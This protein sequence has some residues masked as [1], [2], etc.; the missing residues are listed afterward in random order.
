MNATMPGRS[1]SATFVVASLFIC[2]GAGAQEAPGGQQPRDI[3]LGFNL[4]REF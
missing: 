3:Y 1:L 2:S 4:S